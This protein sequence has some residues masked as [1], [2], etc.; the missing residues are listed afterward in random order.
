[1]P[2]TRQEQEQLDTLLGTAPTP[3]T[4]QAVPQ[5]PGTLP[6]EIA[7]VAYPASFTK[8][9]LRVNIP[10]PAAEV[11]RQFHQQEVKT[12]LAEESAARRQLLKK[13]ADQKLQLEQGIA[14]FNKIFDE[15]ETDIPVI[16]RPEDL[17]KGMLPGQRLG[18]LV[19]RELGLR[20]KQRGTLSS[21]QARATPSLKS[22]GEV[23]VLTNQDIDRILKGGF[24]A[25]DDTAISR[26]QKR[27][28]LVTDL[29]MKL[30]AVNAALGQVGT[31]Q[32]DQH[33]TEDPYV[34]EARRRGLLK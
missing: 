2:L 8:G 6:P 9:G 31:R 23:G 13:A 1:M 33:V 5:V 24:P 20:E 18:R 26:Q 29:Q 21:L 3:T 14:L 28:G 19:G 22:L 34:A 30:N 17:S 11:Q 4:P 16:E 15:A 27:E 32:A 7:G 10:P 25:D 12:R